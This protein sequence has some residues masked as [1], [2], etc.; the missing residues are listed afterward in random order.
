MA[1][2]TGQKLMILRCLAGSA[3]PLMP[4]DILARDKEIS[5]FGIYVAL[6]R[7]HADG[8]LNSKTDADTGGARGSPHRRYSINA[9]GRRVLRMALEREMARAEGVIV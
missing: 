2:P 6:A 5:E 3:T 4:A 1:L 8:W 9:V 7:M